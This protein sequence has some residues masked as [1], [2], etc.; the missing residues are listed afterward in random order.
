M[1]KEKMC[2]INFG[3]ML[4]IFF[5][6]TT[7]NSNA[8]G[9]HTSTNSLVITKDINFEIEIQSSL[10]VDVEPVLIDFGDIQRNT[11]N[12]IRKQGDL[13]FKAAFDKDVQVRVDYEKEGD[14][15]PND[16]NYAKYQMNYVNQVNENYTDTIDVYL[17]RINQEI[18]KQGSVKIPVIGEI[19]EVGNV[20]LGEY[21][22][23]V[24]A[25]VY[26]T[27]LSPTGN[28]ISLVGE[29]GIK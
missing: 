17:K 16:I 20:R 11:T 15:T 22:K 6:I 7:L 5:F 25:D 21:E 8:A 28:S 9:T 23:T 12:M 24:K 10:A 18:L 14:L 3:V 1:K 29:G 13:N 27:P 19:R 2:K 26:V 4:L